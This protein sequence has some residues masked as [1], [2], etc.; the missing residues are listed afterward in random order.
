[1][2]DTTR[3]LALFVLT[4]LAFSAFAAD[5]FD[6]N[7][8]VEAGKVKPTRWRHPEDLPKPRHAVPRAM[9]PFMARQVAM[10][11]V[12][13]GSPRKD[14][15]ESTRVCVLVNTSIRSAID[16]ALTQYVIDLTYSGFTP[17]IVESSG[18]TAED[19]R[20]LLIG[21]YEEEP[22]SLAGA[23]LIGD[24]PYIIY[25]M[26]QDWDAGG[27]DPPEY[28]DFP[29]DLFYMD[30]DGIWEDSLTDGDVLPDNGKY[31]TRSG[32]TRLEIWVCRMRTSQLSWIGGEVDLLNTYFQQNHLHRTGQLPEGSTGLV[33]NDNDW[34]Y[35]AGGDTTSVEG[36]FGAGN[37]ETVSE[38]DKTN[39]S[40]FKTLRLTTNY[41]LT[42][43]RSHGYPGGHG[44]YNGDG[45]PFEWVTCTDYISIDPTTRFYS[46]FVC[47]GS[48]YVAPNFLGGIVTFNPAGGG[49]LSWGSAKTGGMLYDSNLYAALEAGKCFGAAFVDWYSVAD[50]Y[51]WTPRWFYGMVLN[52]D[53]TLVALDT[54]PPTATI[55]ILSGTPTGDDDIDFEVTFSEH[56]APTFTAADVTLAGTLAAAATFQV[57]GSDPLYT[58]TA[59]PND[60][61]ADGTLG[62]VIGTDVTDL[63]GNPYAG[64]ASDL[65]TVNNWYGF[66][67]QPQ[68]TK[69]Y[70][71]D[72]HAFIAEGTHGP[73]TPTY[74]WWWDN[75][76]KDLEPVGGN[77]NTY[78]IESALEAY[79]GIYQC[80]AVYAGVSHWSDAATLEVAEHIEITQQP[81]GAVTHIGR[82]HTFEVTAEGGHQPLQYIWQKD[83]VPTGATGTEYT[84]THL[85]ESDTGSYV[86]EI[87]D[88]NTAIVH[89]DPAVLI[90]SGYGLPIAGLTGLGL[91]T[92]ACALA[93]VAALR[94]D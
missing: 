77:S 21:Y 42:L 13:L 31:D 58:V 27:P 68:D 82:K 71:G 86:A 52:G 39:A 8:A 50:G 89:S 11:K 40:D 2:I 53:A 88:A 19:L 41:K 9:A 72:A 75:G 20:A 92:A 55:A 48:D 12:P 17:F 26:M 15:E 65:C 91:L 64:G 43:I 5:D 83:G 37:V 74:Q 85:E 47:S 23:V 87:H 14:E 94:K 45:G 6:L 66:T 70:V 79:S 36:V 73:L 33:Y 38:P 62:I 22:E 25:E 51:S 57:T 49:M 18:G 78:I 29:C 35:M 67:T 16:A 61:D 56:V 30:L 81:Q 69:L 76:A 28:E 34:D 32:D 59:T 60:P 7:A 93:A 44:F 54:D 1:M 4:T 24:F 63:M 84:I 80:E 10:P 46:L 90:V 3:L